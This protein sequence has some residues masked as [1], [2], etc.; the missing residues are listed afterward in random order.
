MSDKKTHPPLSIS[1]LLYSS[2][3][4]KWKPFSSERRTRI[5][6]FLLLT[7]SVASPLRLDAKSASEIFEQASKSVVIVYNLD[8][9]DNRQQFASGVVMPNGEVATNHHIIEKA[10]RLAVI[11]N[12]K[13]FAAKISHY[14]PEKDICLLDVPDLKAPIALIGNTNQLKVGARVYAICSPSGLELTLSEGIVSGFREMK[15]G[16][17]IQNTAPI[18]SGSSGGGLFDENGLL[19]GL[20]TFYLTEGQQLNFA[21]PVEWVVEES[22]QQNTRTTTQ[23]EQKDWLKQVMILEQKK[24]WPCMLRECQLWIKA[25]PTNSEA[26]YRLG[27]AHSRNGDMRNAI[28]VFRKAVSINPDYSAAWSELGVAYGLSSKEIEAIE[29]FKKATRTKPDNTDAWS[30]LGEAYWRSG[31]TDKAVEA[32]NQALLINPGNV[33][34][35]FNLG[36]LYLSANN[37]EKVM[38]LYRKLKNIDPSISKKFLEKFILPR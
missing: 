16:H 31:Q 24:D 25:Q 11:F 23:K 6:V 2:F 12:G 22:M 35:F 36:R 19:V 38:E 21:V 7:S 29:A 13:A 20:P 30:N 14:D 3:S 17:Y 9:K 32:Y 8:D 34:A 4:R 27:L 26:W 10:A 5:F 33:H 37:Q 18:S 28:A 15:G 1:S